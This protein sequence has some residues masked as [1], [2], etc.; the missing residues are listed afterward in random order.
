MLTLDDLIKILRARILSRLLASG[1][2]AQETNSVNTQSVTEHMF[3]RRHKV[4]EREK[5]AFP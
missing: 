4:S 2:L 3:F 5:N 1:T